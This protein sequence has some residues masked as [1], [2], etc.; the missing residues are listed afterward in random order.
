M[1]LT[2]ASILLSTTHVY[3]YAEAWVF[4]TFPTAAPRPKKQ[5]SASD[6]KLQTLHSWY[7][8]LV[9]ILHKAHHIAPK[10]LI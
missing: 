2:T 9:F 8:F 7:T 3:T 10:T 6:K 4:L 1:Q 5:Y